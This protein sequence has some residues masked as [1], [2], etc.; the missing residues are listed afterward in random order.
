VDAQATADGEEGAGPADMGDVVGVSNTWEIGE[1]V[2]VDRSAVSR[3][4]N[5]VRDGHLAELHTAPGSL[6]LFNL[7]RFQDNCAGSGVDCRVGL[8][9]MN[10]VGGSMRLQEA[11]ARGRW[12][13]RKEPP[14][15]MVT[16]GGW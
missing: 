12:R 14:Q 15:I 5:D 3:V 9:R 11:W 1:A 2:G 10:C 7:W 6:P 13:N 4:V 16:Q 8:R